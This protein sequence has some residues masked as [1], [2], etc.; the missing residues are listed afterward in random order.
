MSLVLGGIWRYPVKSMAGESLTTTTLTSD[1]IPGDRVVWVRGPEGV[2]TARR[3]YRLLGL[4]G[5]QSP[6][7]EALVNGHPWDSPA[8][9]QLVREA[10]GDDA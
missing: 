3:Q 9:A 8:A 6:E 2:R 7:G 10:A 4:R 5:T 1:G